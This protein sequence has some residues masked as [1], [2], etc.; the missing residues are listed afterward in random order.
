[1]AKT[2]YIAIA[3]RPNVGKSTLMNSMIGQKL[4]ITAHKPQTTRHAIHGI[5]TDK[6][7]QMIFVDTPGLHTQKNTALNKVLN[8]SA[9]AS[10]QDVDVVVMVV[11]AGQWTDED[12]FAHKIVLQAARPYMIVVNKI[13]RLKS[14]EL[15]LPYLASLPSGDD[16]VDVVPISAKTGE[17]LDELR[18][19]LTQQLPE[20][21][22][23]FSPDQL[24]D[25]SE[26][27][28]A[29]EIV[30]EQLTR[31]LDAELP[32][33]LTVEI[34]RFV[35]EGSLTRINAVIWVERDSQKA[36]VIGKKGARLK[37]VG[38]L[39]RKSMQ[40]LFDRKVHLEL[41]VKVKE[42]WVDDARALRHL[43][44]GAD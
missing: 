12:A 34:E 23:V 31:Q 40:H 20:A 38:T 1:M 43:G 26:K 8:R 24:T 15:L 13:D 30:R 27:F 7:V 5:Y 21:P 41:W 10:L 42:N 39:A 2:G 6:N 17:Q 4:S 3:G 36:I 11:E 29:S 37:Q 14:K 16:L 18:A 33:A 32:Y 22:F 35:D 28:L 9:N 19:R 25:V 44:Y